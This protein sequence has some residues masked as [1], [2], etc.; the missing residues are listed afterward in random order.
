MAV[1]TL[2]NGVSAAGAGS[3]SSHS[4]ACTVKIRGD[5][6]LKGCTV[7][8]EHANADT[9]NQYKP[10]SEEATLVREGQTVNVNAQGTYYL[11]GNV[12]PPADGQGIRTGTVIYLESNTA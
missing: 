10:F 8:V 6:D 9:A 12:I 2:L 11:R 7:V 4:A 3:G 1:T 5:S